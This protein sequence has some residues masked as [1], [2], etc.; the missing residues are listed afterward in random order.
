MVD[1][2]CSVIILHTVSHLYLWFFKFSHN[3]VILMIRSSPDLVQ[4][5]RKVPLSDQRRRLRWLVVLRVTSHPTKPIISVVCESVVLRVADHP[6]KPIPSI[7]Y[8]EIDTMRLSK[9]LIGLSQED[10]HSPRV[11]LSCETLSRSDG[12]VIKTVHPVYWVV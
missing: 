2:I 4:V 12:T 7:V 5:Y 3:G 10:Q 6:K 9:R 8:E 1:E 11:F